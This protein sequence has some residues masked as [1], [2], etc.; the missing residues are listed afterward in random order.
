MSIPNRQQ[1]LLAEHTGSRLVK[2]GLLK[3]SIFDLKSC[4]MLSCVCTAP[5]TRAPGGTYL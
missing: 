1:Y 5:A 2:V 3:D 4:K